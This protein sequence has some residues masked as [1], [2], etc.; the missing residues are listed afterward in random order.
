MRNATMAAFA[1]TLLVAAACA[2]PAKATSS[3]ANEHPL[4]YVDSSRSGSLEFLDVQGSGRARR[5]R[6]ERY[7][8]DFS[9]CSGVKSRVDVRTAT[10]RGDVIDLGGGGSIRV[11]PAELRVS[12]LGTRGVHVFRR[13]ASPDEQARLIR[14]FSR[15]EGALRRSVHFK[16]GSVGAE[17]PCKR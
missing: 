13:L 14:A 6:F 16:P 15:R 2:P 12:E 8:Q 3:R 10:M 17:T 5:I 1:G 11:S 4:R 9:Y 7:L